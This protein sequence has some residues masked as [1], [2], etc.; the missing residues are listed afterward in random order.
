MWEAVRRC[1]RDSLEAL[2]TASPPHWHL[3]HAL[4]QS[5][6]YDDLKLTHRLLQ[7]GADPNW[8]MGA[9]GFGGNCL[10][11]AVAL[12]TGAGV[13]EA[14]LKHGAQVEFNDRDGR[15]PLAHAVCLN[16]DVSA[17]LLRRA[18]AREQGVR[19][20]DRWVGAC[21]AH[22]AER[23]RRTLTAGI[24]ELETRG[25]PVA[26]PGCPQRRCAGGGAAAPGRCRC[27]LGRRR[28]AAG[29]PPG[30]A[31]RRR[32][33]VP[34][35]TRRRRGSVGPGLRR[36]HRAGLRSGGRGPRAAGRTGAGAG[37]VTTSSAH[38]S[39]RRPGAGRRVRDHGGRCRRRRS[40]E[41]AGAASRASRA[42]DGAFLAPAPLHAAA[43]PRRQ[44]GG[45]RAPEDARE[46]GG[47]DR[48]AARR[49]QR[50]ECELLHVPRRPGADCRGASG[51]Q[52]RAPGGA[53]DAA[54][55]GGA[56]P[57]RCTPGRGLHPAGP[58]VRGRTRR[59]YGQAGRPR[60]GGERHAGRAEARAGLA[61][62]RRG[63]R[64][65]ARPT[66]PPRC[67]W[68]RST[69]MR[70]WSRNCWPAARTAACA[71]TCSTARPPAGPT[72]AA[73]PTSPT[74]W[75]SPYDL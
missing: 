59:P 63:G 9:W 74:G 53:A 12:G 66:G 52:C 27:P 41:S 71:T 49:R 58:A 7:A 72:P 44:R 23:S 39:L 75:P 15:P 25:S 4:P 20:V 33:G 42:R 18:G 14:L 13:V 38:G 35:A 60:P 16:R 67:T 24:E 32:R 54:N 31:R 3:C 22:D 1:D 19:N 36:P 50:S 47:G 56:G 61:E 37:P 43:L 65:P 11:E 26:L 73:T 21:F 6:Q 5:L 40:S 48:P 51:G 10:H 62:R 55:D 34:G 68:P 64:Q 2:L 70:R 28:W 57:R 8:T 29:D 30:R 45:R 17:G 69:A 46:R